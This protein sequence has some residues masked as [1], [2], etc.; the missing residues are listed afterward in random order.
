MVFSVGSSST[1][2]NALTLAQRIAPNGGEEH[3]ARW[4]P[5]AVDENFTTNGTVSAQAGSVFVVL[6]GVDGAA[7]S[8]TQIGFNGYFEFT[9]VWE[10]LPAQ[11]AGIAV[12]PKAPVPYTSQQVL[13]TISDLGA[14]I[15]KGARTAGR[16]VGVING[17][18]EGVE[19]ILAG[20]VRQ[21]GYRPP[22]MLL[23]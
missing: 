6:R 7:Y 3:E 16:I 5:S 22:P 23:R 8:T 10:W 20:G 11:G 21:R 19:T 1:A 18:M 13:G 2:G 15:F 14:Y 4:L 17:A 12:A 9:T